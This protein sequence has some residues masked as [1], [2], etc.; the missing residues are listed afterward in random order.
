MRPRNLVVACG[1]SQLPYLC[2]THA[3]FECDEWPNKRIVY[4]DGNGGGLGASGGSGTS[5]EHAKE[6]IDF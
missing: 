5:S 2:R 3:L 6:V 4:C 1:H